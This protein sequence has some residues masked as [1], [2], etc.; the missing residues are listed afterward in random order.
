MKK[1][2]FDLGESNSGAGSTG[3]RELSTEEISQV[4]GGG[5]WS[6]VGDWALGVALDY[7]VRNAPAAWDAQT[8]AASATASARLSAGMSVI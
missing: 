5:I 2:T 3:I 1:S 8:A 6:K 4:S 7:G